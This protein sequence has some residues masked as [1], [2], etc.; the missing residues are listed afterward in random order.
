MAPP[1]PRTTA[2]T[3]ARV[4]G[5]IHRLFVRRAD[6]HRRAH[7]EVLEEMVI[8]SRH[9]GRTA[10]RRRHRRRRDRHHVQVIMQIQI[11]TPHIRPNVLGVL[12]RTVIMRS[13]FMCYNYLTE[14]VNCMYVETNMVFFIY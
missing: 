11:N 7:Q 14:H 6:H 12:G 10:G 8:V 1:P 5:L 2:T 13:V 4:R 3:V 9:R